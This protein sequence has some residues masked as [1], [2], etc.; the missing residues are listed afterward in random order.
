MAP[1]RWGRVELVFSARDV[2]YVYIHPAAKNL[3]SYSH[4]TSGYP[5]NAT[6]TPDGVT[7]PRSM[8]LPLEEDWFSSIP[9]S[10]ASSSSKKKANARKPPRL[11][12]QDSISSCSD[13]WERQPASDNGAS[14]SS[15]T[16]Y[17]S[18]GVASPSEND[19]QET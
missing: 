15:D 16:C 14:S 17:I 6:P 4:I 3:C 10:T 2:I 5:V 11:D 1:S 9:F 18:S 12:R 8:P 19:D 13:E 7:L